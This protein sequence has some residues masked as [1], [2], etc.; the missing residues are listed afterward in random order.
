MFFIWVKCGMH[1]MLHL[2]VHVHDVCNIFV[3]GEIVC[4]IAT[5]PILMVYLLI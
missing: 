4:V 3:L 2:F 5:H 1:V